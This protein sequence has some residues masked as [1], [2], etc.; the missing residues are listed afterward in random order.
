MSETS[1]SESSSPPIGRLYDEAGRPIR[2][3]QAQQTT[4]E[5]VRFAREHPVGTALGALALGYIL[6][7]IS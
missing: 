7:K 1:S 6:G 2:S 5:L 3:G 4:E